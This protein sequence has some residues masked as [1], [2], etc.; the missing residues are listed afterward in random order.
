[1]ATPHSF[2]NT[3][4]VH[5]AAFFNWL[6][7]LRVDY[8]TVGAEDRSNFPILRV[9]ASP[10]RA[11]ASVVDL[12]VRLCW[13]DGATAQAMRDNADNFAVLPLPV[14]TIF[15]GDST[16]DPE[17]R[18][19]PKVFRKR[20]Y[21]LQTRQWE[22]HPWPGHYRTPYTVSFWMTRRYTEAF[23]REWVMAQLGQRGV[24][25]TE[26]LIPVVHAAPWETIRQALRFDDF[27][28]NSELEGEEPRWIRFDAT[29]ALRTWLFRVVEPAQ[30]EVQ[31]VGAA[32]RVSR[33][34]SAVLPGD[35]LG[36][37]ALGPSPEDV[38]S[39]NLYVV[40]IPNVFLAT[41]MVKTG[42]ATVE[43]GLL[44]PAGR[45]PLRDDLHITAEVQADAVT[46]GEWPIVPD[47][48]GVAVYSYAFQYLASD[49]VELET[50]Q[51]DPTADVIVSADSFVLPR[52]P[53]WERFHLFTLVRGEGGPVA[54]EDRTSLILR[55]AGIP[56]S[57]V[58]DVHLHAIDVRHVVRQTPVAPAT[59]VTGG[60][61]V[62]RTWTGL[63]KRG[64]LVILVL[65]ATSGGA[66]VAVF[67]DDAAVP[68]QTIQR[69]LDASVNAGAAVLMQPSRDSLVLKVPTSM[70]VEAA[71][72]QVFDGPFNGHTIG[73]DT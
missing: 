9:F 16:P 65:T 26:V 34:G 11:F 50:L 36:D 29:F 2:E 40:P 62:T 42:D 60:G 45:R 51:R 46:V 23:I 12:L 14:A 17:L 44:A 19:T 31:R 53:R 5:D 57:A 68:T 43:P 48:D 4:R 37:D 69:T 24:A 47:A 7:G 6:G 28:D 38:W 41:V 20:W 58:Q 22:Q 72:I 21:N 56:P 8:G 63:A 54:V 18:G 27:A 32:T 70:T 33:T 39:E 25:E 52:A 35:E 55:V 59:T 15:R 73:F 1:M 13:I 49:P 61:F 3:L 64:Y 71:Y 67:T 30:E 10:D 66:N